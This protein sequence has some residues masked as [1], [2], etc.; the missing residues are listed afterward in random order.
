LYR[1]RRGANGGGASP[2]A[3]AV[4]AYKPPPK[5]IVKAA[6]DGKHQGF[7]FKAGLAL[8]TLFWPLSLILA[9]HVILAFVTLFWPS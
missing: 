9:C 5:A 7:K 2:S 6:G 8:F 1:L 4:A 3:H